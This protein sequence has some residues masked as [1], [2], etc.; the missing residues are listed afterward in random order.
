MR[1]AMRLKVLMISTIFM[2]GFGFVSV[3]QCAIQAMASRVIYD[4]ANKAAT[5]GLKNNANQAYMIQAWV[6]PG[7]FNQDDV[8][9]FVVTPPLIKIESQKEATLRFIYAGQGLPTDRESQFWISIQEI[10]PKP[11]QENILQLA[12]RS[13]IKLFYRPIQIN[14]SLEDAVKNLKWY[15]KDQNLYLE[16]N[17]PLHVTIGD[18]KLNDQTTF[19]KYMNQDMVEPYSK[20]EVLKEITFPLKKIEF[21]YINEFGG[22]KIMP[23]VYLK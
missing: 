13:K 10:P 15:V 19:V 4:G 11:S 6:E 16:N 3:A 14:I 9:P 21:T 2:V 20:I 1:F 7:T 12:I 5:L 23:L 18:L 22:N 8:V 17:S